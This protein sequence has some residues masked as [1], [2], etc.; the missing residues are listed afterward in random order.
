L[1]LRQVAE[2]LEALRCSLACYPFYCNP[3]NADWLDSAIHGPGFVDLL[4]EERQ[5]RLVVVLNWHPAGRLLRYLAADVAAAA[6][7]ASPRIAE[8]YLA[9]Q[10]RWR[11]A[12]RKLR[13][14]R[15]QVLL[16]YPADAKL[17]RTP[18]SVVATHAEGRSAAER[19]WRFW[20]R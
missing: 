18:Q 6:I 10:A 19:I 20:N 9:K 5:R 12:L 15:Q 14:H 7:A 1:D 8:C 2:P 17:Q 13:K 11:S 4:R 3:T 16:V